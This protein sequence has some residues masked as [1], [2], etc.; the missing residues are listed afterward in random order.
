[1]LPAR[2][3]PLVPGGQPA[4]PGRSTRSNRG[5]RN[6]DGVHL[7]GRRAAGFGLQDKVMRLKVG[8]AIAAGGSRNGGQETALAAMHLWFHVNDMLP[9]GIKAPVTQWGPT[10]SGG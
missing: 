2:L 7:P 4:R 8:G 3:Y 9:V 6:G 5:S 1:M 10:S